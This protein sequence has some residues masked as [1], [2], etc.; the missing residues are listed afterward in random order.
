M[1]ERDIRCGRNGNEFF[2]YAWS[3]SIRT[4]T[5]DHQ[6][7]KLWKEHLTSCFWII[8][9]TIK[10][11]V[12]SCFRHFL[13]SVSRNLLHGRK[14]N[15]KLLVCRSRKQFARNGVSKVYRSAERREKNLRR[16]IGI[17]FP[18]TGALTFQSVFLL[19][20]SVIFQ[21]KNN[22]NIP[23]NITCNRFFV[24]LRLHAIGSWV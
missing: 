16:L 2:T 4:A 3:E 19:L 7:M 9:Q 15:F 12:V 20:F 5:T 24:F 10:I 11:N 18:F 21:V 22:K 1:N 17:F 8:K 6:T 14:L 13:F 23:N